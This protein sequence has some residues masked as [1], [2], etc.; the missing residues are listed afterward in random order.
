M[1]KTDGGSR[2]CA[3]IFLRVSFKIQLTRHLSSQ[4][5]SINPLYLSTI[6]AP[7]PND[8]NRRRPIDRKTDYVLSYSHCDPNISSLYKRLETAGQEIIGHT[9]DTFTKRTAFFFGFEVKTASGDHTE[10]ELQM[11][12]WIAASL[13]KK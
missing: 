3:R 9:L 1:V 10:V 4:S 13:R 7:T 5:Q 6:S 11:S 2:A 8:L 12:I